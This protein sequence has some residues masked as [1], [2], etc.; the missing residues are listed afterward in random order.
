MNP[1]IREKE[2]FK[3][4]VITIQTNDTQ[5]QNFVDI[6][7]QH[8][9]YFLDTY[10]D[11]TE[12]LQMSPFTNGSGTKQFATGIL[13]SNKQLT[14]WAPFLRGTDQN[15]KDIILKELYDLVSYNVKTQQE[16]E[17]KKSLKNE[18]HKLSTKILEQ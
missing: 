6:L 11:G 5:S 4:L 8:S 1:A 14:K 2:E 18:G 15:V 7:W 10:L 16:M 17:I 12:P 13:I 3:D 9:K